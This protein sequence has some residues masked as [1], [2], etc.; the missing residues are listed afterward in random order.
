MGEA[1]LSPGEL[2]QYLHQQIPLAQVMGVRVM[3]L[4]PAAVT[5]GAPLEPNIN[6]HETVFGGAAA[7]VALLAGWSLLHLRLRS[8][9]LEQRLVIQ[10]HSMEHERPITAAFTARAQLAPT[11]E[12][13]QFA[14]MLRRRGKARI[15]VSVHLEQSGERV[16][17]LLGEFVAMHAR[18]SG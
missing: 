17:A 4:S 15:G 1:V 2:E 11:A 13:S 10:R 3:A 16:A 7:S 18:V 14:A 12:W 8:S 5:L 6:H 9:G